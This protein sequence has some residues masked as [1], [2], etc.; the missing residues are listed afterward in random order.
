MEDFPSN[1]HT[2]KVKEPIKKIEKVTKGKI[3]VKK[4]GFWKKLTD[5]FFGDD[6]DSVMSY[7]IYDILIP[8]TKNTFSDVISGSVEMLLFGSTKGGR[9]LERDRGRSFVS[10]EPYTPYDRMRDSRGREPNRPRVVNRHT[11][12]EVAFSVRRDAEAVLEQLVT[13]VDQYG[14]A[15]VGDFYDLVGMENSFTDGKYGWYNLS[16]AII[17]PSRRGF[18][19]SLPRVVLLD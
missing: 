9:R 19:I 5:T 12:D 6:V 1:S 4:K 13:L 2:G 7:V 15:T 8:V 17:T 18:V 3:L 16:E 10:R 11:F 14:I